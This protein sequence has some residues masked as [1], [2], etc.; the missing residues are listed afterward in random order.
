M[1]KQSFKYVFQM[2]KLITFEVSYYRCGNNE[3]KYFA[4]SANKLIRSKRDYCECG[5][6]QDSLLPNFNTAYKFYKKW[7]PLHLKD[8]TNEQYEELLIDIEKLKSRYNYI[9]NESDRYISFYDVVT[10]SKL[11]PKRITKSN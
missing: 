7:D 11:T 1:E 10:L 2:T 3:N 8:L 6:A 4:T 5:Q 9:Y